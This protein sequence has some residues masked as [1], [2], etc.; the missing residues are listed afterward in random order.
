MIRFRL[1]AVP[2]QIHLS[3]LL[4]SAYIAWS[5]MNWTTAPPGWPRDVLTNP[6]HPFRA[7]TTIGVALVW[8]LLVSISVLAHEMGHAVVARFFGATPEIHLVGLGGR[9]LAHRSGQFEWWQEVVFTLAGPGAGLA[10]GVA[11]GAIAYLGKS[12]FPSGV[13]YFGTGILYANVLWTILNLL[14]ITGL[15]GGVITTA[16]LTRIF[17]RPGFLLA[18][19]VAV[20]LSALVLWWALSTQQPLMVMLVGLMSLRTV[21]NILGY[22]RGEAPE[23]HAVHPLHEVMERAESLYRERQLG[24]AER[25]AVGAMQQEDSPPAVRSRAHMLLGWIAL[26]ASNGRSALDHFSQVQGLEVPPHALAA[27]F[28][29]VGDE[30]RA[31]PLWALASSRFP[32]DGLVLH[33]YAGALIR[34][35][36]EAEARQLPRVD[37]VRAFSAAERVHYVRKEFESGAIA[38]QNAYHAGPHPTLAYTAACAW[39]LAGKPEEAMRFLNLASQLGFRD[40]EQ[41][42]TDPDFRSLRGRADFQTW[43]QSLKQSS[44]S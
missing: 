14:P 43:M 33:E 16:I 9:T 12:V 7:P 23:S 11:A 4:I 36:R 35:G 27:G 22:I 21:S 39:A 29:L 19:L 28:S 24:E 38:A 10:F 13:L 32:D 31:I 34:G 3:H 2:V 8:M 20:A 18:Q 25:L 40:A 30:T 1:A 6:E 17:G 44:P 15:D 42:E 26:K 41:A 5:F 37:L